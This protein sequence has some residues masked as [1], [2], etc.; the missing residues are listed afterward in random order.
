MRRYFVIAIVVTFLTGCSWIMKLSP[1]WGAEKP[2]TPEQKI[3]QLMKG[4]LNLKYRLG[5]QMEE[6]GNLK[7]QIAALSD[8][9][10]ELGRE[11]KTSAQLQARNLLYKKKV[12]ELEEEIKELKAKIAQLEMKPALKL[13]PTTEEKK[14]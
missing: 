2:L 7:S 13:K 8:L 14:N 5:E 9:K 10:A 1:G 3:E 12:K 11:M 6:L 4:A